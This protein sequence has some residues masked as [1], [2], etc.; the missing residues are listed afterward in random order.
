M[1]TGI[2]GQTQ[3]ANA[4]RT[5]MAEADR[6]GEHTGVYK[7]TV[8]L[9][10][11][12]RKMGRNYN[13]PALPPV[14]AVAALADEEYDSPQQISDQLIT[15]TPAEVIAQVQ[16][17]LRAF[18]TSTLNQS[19]LGELL[20]DAIE[21]KRDADG[22]GQYDNFGGV[23]GTTST[24]LTVDLIAKACAQIRS[25]RASSGA[26]ARTGARTTGDAPKGKM[27]AVFHEYNRFD[28]ASQLSGVGGAPSQVTTGAAVMNFT[29][30]HISPFMQKFI[31]QGAYVQDIAGA[32]FLVDNNFTIAST[33]IKGGVY[34]EK[35]LV[36]ITFSDYEVHDF[37]SK[38]G[39]F[40]TLTAIADYG[41]LER[42]DQYGREVA[43]DA[44][45]PS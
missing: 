36:H 19:M 6:F 21:Q 35:A 32:S 14:T 45:A 2:I 16:Y 29:A 5:L 39:R 27:Y 37:T 13:I 1:T 38:D 28:I 41:N 8:D 30:T 24:T 20:S 23:L 40:I 31:E 3:I 10:T 17:G 12:P 26:T 43:V 44:T 42:A 33:A 11:L 18:A 7:G 4:L 34:S 15:G 25:G 22:L 9:R